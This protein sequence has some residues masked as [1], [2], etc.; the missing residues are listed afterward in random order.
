[1]SEDHS[2]ILA[3]VDAVAGAI[4]DRISAWPR[5]VLTDYELGTLLFEQGGEIGPSATPALY[6]AVV[7]RLSSYKLLSPSKEFKSA[8]V[9]HLFGRHK[10]PPAEVACSVDP[11]A[12]VSHLSAME[13]HGITDRFPK[14]LFLC[15]PPAAEWKILAAEKMRKDLGSRHDDYLAAK[16]PVLRFLP[17][18]A[19][20]GVRVHLLRRS[21]RG[22]FK[23][24]KSP[25]IRVATLGRTFLDMLREP[26]NCG[27]IQHVIDT[28]REYAARYLSLIVEEVDRHGQSIDKVRAGFLLD[29]VCKLKHPML[30]GWLKAVQRG[31]SRMLDPQGEYAAS[32]SQKWMLSVN[33]PS[34]Q[35][36]EE[37]GD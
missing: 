9:F 22:A 20:E 35:N 7:S 3:Q 16:L 28:Y 11:F 19:V 15:T 23:I 30:D 14:T 26:D 31:G 4:A 21:K 8:A 17:F 29:E 27:G 13:F 2:K 5:P 36:Q 18:S 12:Y 6:D 33:V 1:M 34:L 37:T 24:I 25:P 10:S 32:F